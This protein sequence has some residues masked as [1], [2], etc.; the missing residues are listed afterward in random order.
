MPELML[1]IGI[2]SFKKIRTEG[3]YYVDKTE[4]VARLVNSGSY[5]FL[6]RPRRFGK[7]LFLN[8]ITEAFSGKKEL[9][10][11]LYLSKPEANWD[12]SGYPVLRVD[13]SEDPPVTVEELK[14]QIIEMIDKW[15]RIYAIYPVESTFGKRF[16]SLVEQIHEK[17][18]KPVV[19]LIDEYDKPILDHIEDQKLANDMKE[20]LKR[21]YT[22]IKSLDEHL[23]F[24]FITGVSKF[25][26]AGIFSGLN[27]LKDITLSKDYSAICGY[28]QNELEVTFARHLI[29]KDLN[30]IKKW[31]DGYSWT[32]VNVYNPFDILL[33]LSEDGRYSDYWFR[34]GTPEFITKVLSEKSFSLSNIRE[35]KLDE[36]S[37]DSFQ[38]DNIE[39]IGLLFQT[40]YLTI[41][42]VLLRFDNVP[43]YLLDLPNMEVRLAF[44]KLLINLY[45]G[46]SPI[47]SIGTLMDGLYLDDPSLVNEAFS[48]FLKSI[49]NNWYTNNPI[50]EY[51]GYYSAV[52][53]AFLFGSGFMVTAED[54]TSTGRIDLS[55]KTDTAVWIFEFKINGSGSDPLLQ[56]KKKDYAGKF[57]A[58][59]KIIHEIGITFN[60][61]KREIE[62]FEVS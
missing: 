54:P 58:E 21:F 22:S 11:G 8:T 51:E 39:P 28:T 20:T 16:I 38:I 24:V 43:Q 34:S 45:T 6:S 31:Y 5:Y 27:N 40:G 47:G 41:T 42:R 60:S 3:Y 59:G 62:R 4:Y 32:G 19:L 25:A 13:W 37:L 57:K 49:P 7:S 18:G 1:P 35:L 30:Q 12:F 36:D 48:A 9:F 15:A 10:D 46:K 29:D 14:I 56:I 52:I 26:G 50:S 55:L 44:S 61:E 2:Q 17:I 33:F 53:Y 23:K